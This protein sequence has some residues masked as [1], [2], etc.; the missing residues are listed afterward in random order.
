MKTYLRLIAI[1]FF[2]ALS[3]TNYGQDE[4]IIKSSC[5]YDYDGNRRFQ[6][7]AIY[8]PIL[9]ISDNYNYSDAKHYKSLSNSTN[10]DTYMTVAKNSN[11]GLYLDYRDFQ[12]TSS[13]NPKML[14]YKVTSPTTYTSQSHYDEIWACHDGCKTHKGKISFE[15]VAYDVPKVTSVNFIKLC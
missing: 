12:S 15:V 9:Y 7:V 4:Y 1:L 5:I 3:I 8:Y 2:S 11:V 6:D 13:W 14:Y 10:S